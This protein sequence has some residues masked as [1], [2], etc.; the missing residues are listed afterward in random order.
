ML[1]VSLARR[2]G[3]VVLGVPGRGLPEE[4]LPFATS[5]QLIPVLDRVSGLVAHDAHAFCPRRAFDVEDLVALESPKPRMRQVKRHREP[6]YATG[7][8]PFVREPHVRLEYE[9]SRIQLLVQLRDAPF[10]PRSLDADAEV[11]GPDPEQAVIAEAL[12]RKAVHVLRS[13]GRATGDWRRRE[14][15]DGQRRKSG[16]REYLGCVSTLL[17]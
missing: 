16:G 11:L 15:G 8:K 17:L 9:R 4:L 5:V 6:R 14:Q 3:P 1:N 13:R 10:Q 7:G 2:V 12:P